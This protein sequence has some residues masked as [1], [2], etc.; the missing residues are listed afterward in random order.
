MRPRQP[1]PSFSCKNQRRVLDRW[2]AFSLDGVYYFSSKKIPCGQ[3]Q[4]RK[5]GENDVVYLHSAITPAVVAPEQPHV[6]PYVPEF[7]LPQNGV[8][9]QDCEINA[10]QNWVQREQETLLGYRAILLGDDFYSKQP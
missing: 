4:T 10:A 9:K 5:Q 1:W 8:E 6:L 3:C 7:I 2:L